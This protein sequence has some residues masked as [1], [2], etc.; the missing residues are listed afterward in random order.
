MKDLNKGDLDFLEQVALELVSGGGKVNKELIEK[1]M[2]QVNKNNL[3]IFNKMNKSTVAEKELKDSLC[4][5]VYNRI[6]Q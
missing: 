5:Q 6:N 1:A 3:E 2:N 4:Y